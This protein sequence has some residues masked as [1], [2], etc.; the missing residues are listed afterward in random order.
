MFQVF[1]PTQ[2]ASTEQGQEAIAEGAKSVG[3]A[4]I[5]GATVAGQ[6]ES[7]D[8]LLMATSTLNKAQMTASLGMY[9]HPDQAAQIAQSY[10][11]TAANIQKNTPLNLE[12]KEFY[13][14]QSLYMNNS[15]NFE[16]NKIQ[17]DQGKLTQQLN[18]QS[19]FPAFLNTYRQNL[20]NNPDLAVKQGQDMMD[21]MQGMVKNGVFTPDAYGKFVST[22]NDSQ[23]AATMVLNATN[24]G[25]INAANYTA[26]A[27]N[28]GQANNPNL[29]INAN[30]ASHKIT[31]DS[32]TTYRDSVSGL[33][34]GAPV[35][36]NAILN[37]TPAQ[38]QT[39]SLT[40]QGSAQADGDFQSGMS[41]PAIQAKISALKN[42]KIL[43]YQ[44]Q[45]YLARQE[46]N[47]ENVKNGNALEST[48][49]G[50]A[51]QIETA[52]KM[53]A[54]NN[55][56]ALSPQEKAQATG[57]VINNHIAGMINLGRAQQFPPQYVNPVP[58]SLSINSQNSFAQNGDP[59]QAI[60][61]IASLTPANRPWLAKTMA[62]PA[63]Q[64]AAYSCGLL[65]GTPNQPFC[66]TLIR[67]N[68]DGNDYSKIEAPEGNGS[69]NN[70]INSQLV[71]SLAPQLNYLRGLPNGGQQASMMLSTLNNV[72]KYQA[73]VNGD[74]NLSNMSDYISGI[75]KNM[76]AAFNITKGST[77]NGSSY[78]FNTNEIKIQPNQASN[79]A[80]F[81]TDQ[82]AQHG[83]VPSDTR[84]T[85]NP[86]GDY[87]PVM[88]GNMTVGYSPTGDVIVSDPD[89]NIYYRHP[90][91]ASMQAAADVY[92][93]QQNNSSPNQT[94]LQTIEK[95]IIPTVEAL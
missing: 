66:S 16:A 28:A 62:K 4:S 19:A 60:N 91:T 29:P 74:Y 30:T 7:R 48:T 75:S 70:Y 18:F 83:N 3:Q 6:F 26:Y 36:Y 21:T 84:V 53:A 42:T 71:N 32:D 13:G 64:G 1:Q 41:L 35:N 77:N 22:I 61:T 14:R 20:I 65:I 46:N 12:D 80:N 67:A 56:A 59:N 90:Y 9:E 82:V 92:A 49:A 2:I 40:Q 85:Y 86:I 38:R 44:Q 37:M 34:Q 25:K 94:L 43:T 58:A 79:L 93:S 87:N 52:Q 5:E 89:G 88:Q 54:I 95:N 33:A 45:G 23:Q 47:L 63:Q 50:N 39:W 68:Q 11:A 81:L 31:F 10:N 55:N 73:S 76:G 27:I 17:I 57:Q 51:Q 24:S 78:A 72:V 8:N 15:V 69:V